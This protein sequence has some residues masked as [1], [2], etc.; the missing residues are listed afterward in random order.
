MSGYNQPPPSGYNYGSPPTAQPYAPYGAPPPPQPHTSSQPYN[1][2]G[3]SAP[4]PAAPYGAQPPPQ[5]EKPPKNKYETGTGTGTGMGTGY[6]TAPPPSTHGYGVGGGSSGGG[7]YPPP[8]T[9]GSSPFAALVP[10]VFPPGTDPNIVACFQMA[11]RDGS[12]LIDDIELQSVLSSYNQSFSIRTVH[13]LMYHFTNTNTRKIGPKEFTAVFYSLQ[14]WRSIFERFDRDRSGKIDS[15]ELQQA[16]LSLG[17]SVSPVILDLLVSKFDKSGGRNKAIEYDNFIECCLTVKGLTEKFKE[18]DT[19]YTGSATF[20]YESFML[21]EREPIF[22]SCIIVFRVGIQL[23]GK[24][25]SYRVTAP[26][27]MPCYLSS[28]GFIQPTLKPQFSTLAKNITNIMK[29]RDT[30]LQFPGRPPM[31]PSHMPKPVLD[32]TDE[33]YQGFLL[34]SSHLPKSKDQRNHCQVVRIALLYPRALKV[35]SEGLCVPHSPLAVATHFLHRTMDC[36]LG[37]FSK[38]QLKEIAFGLEKSGQR[39]SWV[40]LS[41]S[42]EDNLK[43]FTTPAE[44]RLNDILTAGSLNKMTGTEV[45]SAGVP[46]V[47]WSLYAEQ[48]INIAI[49]VEEMK[50][51]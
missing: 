31:L 38:A 33:A 27:R 42:Y 6:N 5:G 32:H 10:S 7:S 15:S 45:V 30:T 24:F 43:N 50:L 36:I 29:N 4:P 13:L 14:N 25:L 41:P 34:C 17:F 21:T 19:G 16:L 22:H 51:A 35:I 18:K 46:M 28:E 23:V 12:G 9:Y 8:P 11:D 47:A 49:L 1:P 48:R 37:S 44:P 20:T 40:V 3:A 39:F 2:Y 26:V